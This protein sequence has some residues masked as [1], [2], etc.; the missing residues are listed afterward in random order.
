M[1][2]Q[3]C[4]SWPTG[5]KK[6]TRNEVGLRP[7][8]AR[9]TTTRVAG[10]RGAYSRRGGAE[11]GPERAIDRG[12]R[13]QTIRRADNSRPKDAQAAGD[14]HTA[15]TNCHPVTAELEQ[16]SRENRSNPGCDTQS[17]P[18]GVHASGGVT[19]A[20]TA[21][22][23]L[24]RARKGKVRSGRTTWEWG[25]VQDNSLPLQATRR[26]R[27]ARSNRSDHRRADPKMGTKHRR[28]SGEA[29]EEK[30]RAVG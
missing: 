4:A 10:A 3:C 1:S 14:Q 6:Q 8:H 5:W 25:K 15:T 12:S 26:N 16:R 30:P 29:T 2:R 19:D 23:N 24:Q 11:R 28:R 22:H 13:T 27:V 7:V 18:R 9:G 20:S 17:A 21:T